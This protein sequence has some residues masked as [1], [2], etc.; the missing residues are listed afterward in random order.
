MLT[1]AMQVKAMF[2]GLEETLYLPSPPPNEETV[3][4][5]FG[6]KHIAPKPFTVTLEIELSN[7]HREGQPVQIKVLTRLVQMKELS[8]VSQA[9]VVAHSRSGVQFEPSQALEEIDSA[10]GCID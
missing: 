10:K 2:S 9:T 3:F 1:K 7:G 4:E 5:G 8:S 6:R